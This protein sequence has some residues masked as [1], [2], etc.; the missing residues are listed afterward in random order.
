ML[1]V[2]SS[3]LKKWFELSLYHTL[4]HQGT[5]IYYSSDKVIIVVYTGRS[6][7]IFKYV[8]ENWVGNVG[9]IIITFFQ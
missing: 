4:I 1:Q 6:F 7:G 3:N 5:Y 9:I 8:D 2:V